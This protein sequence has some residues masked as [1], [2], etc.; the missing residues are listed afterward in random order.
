M[1][2]AYTRSSNIFDDSRAT[3]EI[4]AF[5]E[6][7]YKVA[8]Y[9]WNRD[10]EAVRRSRDVFKEYDEEV[11]LFFYSGGVGSSVLEKIRAR[12]LW[13]KWLKKELLR[14]KQIDVIHACDYDTGNAV[15]KVS[16]LTGIG[17]VYDI[18]DYYVDAHPV[19]LIVKSIV[20]KK[21]NEVINDSLTTII[22]TE[23]RI[24]QI[25]RSSQKNIVVIHNSPDVPEIKDGEIKFDYAYC[26]S[27]FGGRL[28]EEILD[29]Y[30]DHRDYRF[31]FAGSGTFAEKAHWISK[32]ERCFTYFGAMPYSEVLKLEMESKILSAIY[33][34]SINNHR[35]CAPNK[36]YEALALGKPVI[37]CKGT[38][39]DKVIGKY[40]IGV[41]IDY[42]ADQFYS[43]LEY[44]IN[45]EKICR[46]M[47][48]RARKLYEE[49]F[50]WKTMKDRLLKIYDCIA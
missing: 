17:Y 10:G 43:A 36:F 9:G 40:N 35:F 7:G 21:E 42:D 16:K 4:F 12:Y 19:P 37:V 45:N 31:A 15:R 11:S 3:K 2:I 29:K 8:I 47:G 24:E 44:L 27:L 48:K 23:E 13:N 41:L 6:N 49:K 46:E 32:E 30:S 18:F 28:I 25:K 26:G 1:L 14:N 22:C 34:P 50:N 38:G 5:L 39:L 20:E 33:D